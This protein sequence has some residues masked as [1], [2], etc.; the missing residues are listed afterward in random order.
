MAY[1]YP[2]AT[3][4]RPVSIIGPQFCAPHPVELA[5]IRNVKT[6][7][8]GE[9]VFTDINGNILFKVKD[10]SGSFS[11]HDRQVLIDA[12]GNPIVTLKDKLMSARDRWQVF[13]GD[14]TDSRDLIFSARTSMFHLKTKLDVFLGNNTKEDVCDFK[15]KGSWSKKS[16][17]IYAG[18][19]STIVAQMH[20][21]HTVQNVLA[22]NDEFMVTVNPDVDYAFIVALIVILGIHAAAMPGGMTEQVAAGS[23]SGVVEGSMAFFLG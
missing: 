13:R 14:S 8:D 18:E 15:V 16:C 22:G 1:T 7:T 5:V 9:F 23:V 4:N 6:I 10:Q 3:A 21:N 11:M 12:S 17:V 2:P 19:T 20:K